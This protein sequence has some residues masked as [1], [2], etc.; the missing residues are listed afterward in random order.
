MCSSVKPGDLCFAQAIDIL[1][2]GGIVAY[3]TETFY[4]L[5]VDPENDQAIDSLYTLK[6]REK[7]KPISL[8]IPDLEYLSKL[9]S[10]VPEPYEKLIESFWPGPLTLI[11]PVID[12][13]LPKLTGGDK[14]IAIRISSSPVAEKLCAA[15]GKA[16][17]ATSAN[18]S[19]EPALVTATEVANL[20]GDKIACII[21]GG[22]APGGKGSTILRYSENK[23][24]CHIVRDGVITRD[25]I[26]AMLPYNYTICNI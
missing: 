14:T 7:K 20:W 23:N 4:G 25:A 6:K 2:N 21:N 9:V 10:S 24:E 12:N 22:S 18:L 15:M 11:F 5:A 17:T 8:L 1:K 13:I 16:I 19:G 26:A 3:P